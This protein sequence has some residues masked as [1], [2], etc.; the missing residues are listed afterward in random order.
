MTDKEV[1]AELK[2]SYEYL[3]DITENA[4]SYH[5]CGQLSDPNILGLEVA[6]R[7]IEEVYCRFYKVVDKEDL[8]VNIKNKD[9]FISDDISGDYFYNDENNNKIFM[10]CLDLDY[11]WYEDTGFLNS[12][13]DDKKD[14]NDY[15]EKPY[16][17]LLNDLNSLKDEKSN[18][19]ARVID[20][21][22]C[23]ELHYV[24]GCA[25][26]EYGDRLE[27]NTWESEIEQIDWYNKKMSEEEISNKLWHI[28]E[29]RYGEVY[30][31][32][33]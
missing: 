12:Y 19:I 5:C 16:F 14:I 1:L 25:T 20:G 8:L 9:Y 10:S 26:I 3:T 7:N 13:S 31:Q 28:Y 6:K 15:K 30:E 27:D 33:I 24:N 23:V 22:H 2:R 11:F 17:L 21:I 32:E 29:E 4:S 18:T